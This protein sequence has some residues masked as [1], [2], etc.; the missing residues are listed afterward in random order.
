MTASASLCACDQ[1]DAVSR[2]ELLR[3]IRAEFQEMPCLR[4]T[5]G[6][7]QRLFGLRADVC[8]RVFAAL[9]AEG[10]L[11]CG[12]DGRYGFPV[13]VAWRGRWSPGEDQH[14]HSWR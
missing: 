5:C 10:T 9:V 2:G 14:V 3:R 4:L 8:Q 6:Q 13:D 1:R 12:P 11:T 7:A